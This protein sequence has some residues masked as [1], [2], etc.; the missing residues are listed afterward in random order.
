MKHADW[1][2]EGDCLPT[3]VDDQVVLPIPVFATRQSDRAVSAQIREKIAA[4]TAGDRPGNAKAT[5]AERNIK[6]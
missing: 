5:T 3:F 4:A 1:T 2:P 6:R